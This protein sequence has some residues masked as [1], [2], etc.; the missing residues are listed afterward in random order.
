MPPKLKM[1]QQIYND[2]NVQ[3]QN[4]QFDFVYKPPR[5]FQRKSHYSFTNRGYCQQDLMFYPKSATAENSYNYIYVI[6]DM[7]KPYKVD[8]EL[9]SNKKN[10]TIIKALSKILQRGII[11]PKLIW[12]DA[13]GE[14]N[15]A[16][17]LHFCEQNNIDIR[18]TVAGRKTQNAIVEMMN[19]YL[20]QAL[21]GYNNY[22]ALLNER[23]NVELFKPK[24]RNFIN[25]INRYWELT[26]IPITLND[27]FEKFTELTDYDINHMFEIGQNV[28]VPKIKNG[29]KLKFRKGDIR[30]KLNHW[31][32]KPYVIREVLFSPNWEQERYLVGEILDNG[33]INEINNISYQRGELLPF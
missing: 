12:S 23:K 32:P 13:G 33:D 29:N 21:M 18:F 6:V 4:P 11:N 1:F 9:I 15:N 28:Y 2:V 16:Q 26:Q 30:Y 7:C 10:E 5:K 8:A 27:Q 24:F 31:N 22:F 25:A 20:R 14:F 17:F 3:M 19:G